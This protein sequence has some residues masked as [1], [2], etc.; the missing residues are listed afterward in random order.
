MCKLTYLEKNIKRDKTK[1]KKS[2]I[3]AQSVPPYN[4]CLPCLYTFRQYMQFTSIRLYTAYAIHASSIPLIQ[5]PHQFCSDGMHE[6]HIFEGDQVYG[7]I[8]FAEFDAV[9]MG[10]G[11]I[12]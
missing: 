10:N 1:S 11:L 5:P 2:L 6:V 3:F 9:I 8:A 12:S 4:P 7:K